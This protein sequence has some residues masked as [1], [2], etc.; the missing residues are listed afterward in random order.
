MMWKGQWFFVSEALVGEPIGFEQVDSD[1]WVAHFGTIELGYYSAPD[2]KLH[3]DR[4]RARWKSGKRWRV[5]H[6]PTGSAAV[7]N[8]RS[9][10][11]VPT[12]KCYRC[13]NLHPEG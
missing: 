13:S 3:L 6:F 4:V 7:T 11:D 8:R 5:S 10:T 1:C 2:R 9:V 12:V